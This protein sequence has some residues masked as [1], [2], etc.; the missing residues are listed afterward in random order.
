MGLVHSLSV[1]RRV[2]CNRRPGLRLETAWWEEDAELLV[3]L[4]RKKRKS[5]YARSSL[6]ATPPPGACL[7]ESFSCLCI[8]E[9]PRADESWPQYGLYKTE[10]RALLCILMYGKLLK[11]FGAVPTSADTFP[12][13][14]PLFRPN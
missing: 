14:R 9:P 3:L 1:R 4:F 2:F 8:A 7:A 13:P 11:W 5:I 12:L 10:R 6:F